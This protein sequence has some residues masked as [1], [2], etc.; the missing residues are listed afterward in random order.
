MAFAQPTTSTLPKFPKIDFSA[1]TPY[2]VTRIIDGDTI[3]ATNGNT[4]ITVRLQGVDTPETKHPR[5]PIQTYGKEA[6]QFLTNLLKGEKVYLLPVKEQFHTGR[7]GRVIAYAYRAPNG[8][9]INAEIIR[10]GYG[11]AYPKYP[12]K[13]T[14]KFQQLE[15]FAKKS[16]KGLWSKNLTNTYQNT[17]TINRR[18]RR[19]KTLRSPEARKKTTLGKWEGFRGLKWGTDIK[20][21]GNMKLVEDGGDIK[22]YERI[23][24]KMAIGQAKLSQLSYIFYKGRFGHVT[25]ETQGWSN[26]NN[27]QRNVFA[28]YGI[29]KRVNESID[30]WIWDNALDHTTDKNVSLLLRYNSISEK[31]QM[32]IIYKPIREQETNDKE[33]EAKAAAE[34]DF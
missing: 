26:W 10:Q 23:N 19:K 14:E 2:E 34:T 8:L 28:R 22:L 27:L 31:A 21:A 29:G 32:L 13:Y 15:R 3:A 7:Y 6:S 5:K 1:Y 9:F 33:R 24:E 30:R 11:H 16:K 4:E 18:R 12:G 17:S 20:D 25:I